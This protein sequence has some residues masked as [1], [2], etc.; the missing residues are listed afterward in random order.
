MQEQT[1]P[2]AS[3]AEALAALDQCY[4]YYQPEPVLVKDADRSIEDDS[5]GFAYYRAA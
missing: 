2:Q 4:A 3:A 5:N 1:E